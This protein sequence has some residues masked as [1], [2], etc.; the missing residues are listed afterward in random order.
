VT[1]PGDPGEQLPNFLKPG[2]D[3]NRNQRKAADRMEARAAHLEKKAAKREKKGKDGSLLRLEAKKI[4]EGVKAL[5]SNG[6]DGYLAFGIHTLDVAM[7]KKGT[8]NITAQDLENASQIA[9]FVPWRG[10][11]SVWVN[12]DHPMWSN[13]HGA[14]RTV[15][16]ESLHGAG[17][18]D[19]PQDRPKAYKRGSPAQ[20]KRFYQLKGTDYEYITPELIMDHIYR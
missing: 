15:G 3:V 12:L 11:S 4:R 19:E 6:S 13:S 9:A 18:D 20:Q 16:H 17:L 1:L 14:R 8:A 10:D 5:R 7:M 2:T